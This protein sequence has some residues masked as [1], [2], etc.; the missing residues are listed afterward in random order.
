[1]PIRGKR[2]GKVEL[3]VENKLLLCSRL[4]REE[5]ES[6]KL[7]FVRYKECVPPLNEVDEALRCTCLQ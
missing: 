4:L 6:E 2:D 5:G 3:W 1:M 7:A